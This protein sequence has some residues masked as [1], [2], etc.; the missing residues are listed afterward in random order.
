MQTPISYQSLFLCL[1]F[2]IGAYFYG[3]ES[4]F[5]PKNGDEYPY[6]HI[7]RMTNVSGHW[8]PLQSE[9]EGIKN[10]KPPLLFWQGMLSSQRGQSWSLIDLRW[11]S[12]LYTALTALLLA[13]AASKVTKNLS[14]GILAGLIWLAF[15]N[16]YRY[17]RPYLAE[18]P[19]I[20]WLSLP[21]FGLLLFGKR[22]FESKWI[23]PLLTGISLGLALLYK[24]IAYVVPVCLVLVAWY[25]QWRSYRILELLGK[26]AV[27]VIFVGAM[28]IACFCLWFVLDP[29]PM[30]IWNEFILG[31]NAGKFAARNSNYLKDMLWGGDSIGM[32]FLSS[33][34]NAGFLSLLVLNL[35]YLAI[36]QYRQTTVE[37]KL[38]WI[39]IAVFF[40]IFCLP[41]QRSGRYLLPI[42][43]A[44]AILLA[45]HWHQLNRLLF[46]VALLIQ[47]ILIIALA[48]L[49]WNIDLWTY[50]VW[51][52]FLLLGSICVIGLGLFRLSLTKSATLLACFMSYL[53]LTSS[54][55][56]LDGTLGRFSKA[57]IQKLQ[58]KTIWFPCDFRAKDEEYRLLIPGAN[59]KG[60]P[61]GEAKEI[62]K[63][64]ERYSL[65]AVQAPV[66]SK[67]ELCAD[68]E[69]IGERF[70]MRARHNDAEIKAM[71]MGQVSDNLF[72]KEY[73]V[74]APFN[75][76]K[77]ISKL[78]DACR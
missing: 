7:V 51:H 50:P 31:E 49:S 37:Q 65:F 20:F 68:C 62:K 36:R 64:A 57:T 74:S 22:A 66:Q 11:P 40:L 9:M 34:A 23:F 47:G 59:I 44:I 73:I 24:S 17:G 78:K 61:A 58:G 29:D 16:T 27:K 14:L 30:A 43:P 69:I 2:A 71:L 55:M 60:Y 39:W 77:D 63:L 28:S 32:L 76:A 6:T 41:S 45:I 26:D 12:L 25:W 3:I 13:L 75:A 21:F 52:W 15:F 48:W 33:I 35:F 54:V 1:V 4:R 46:W 67:L 10:T 56:P 8:L 53:S 70:E 18:P 42:M 38:L 72:V 5:A 19:E